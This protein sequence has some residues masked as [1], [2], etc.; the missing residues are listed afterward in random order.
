MM[1]KGT[2]FTGVT[3]SFF[4]HDGKGNVLF[5]KRS[6]NCRDEHGKWDIGGGSLEFGQ[7]V[8]DTLKKEIE[9]EYGTNVLKYE[10]LGYNDVHR[11]LQEQK[12]HWISLD[13]KVL[14]NR[15]KVK[16]GEPHKFEEIGWFTIDN[17]PQPLHSQFP[18]FLQQ[19]EEKLK[20]L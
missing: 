5:N 14:I 6:K 3:I 1:K 2:D 11:E 13:F 8:I 9:E 18:K 7:S 16:N 4:C 15:D 19:Y 10:F 12:T 20:E 17:L